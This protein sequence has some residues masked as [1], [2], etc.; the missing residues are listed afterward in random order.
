MHH[1]PVL[2]LDGIPSEID[3]ENVLAKFTKAE[4]SSCESAIDY[5]YHPQGR[6]D[7]EQHAELFSH[8]DRPVEWL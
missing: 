1:Q 8:P 6:C 4:R 2:G 5:D 3:V 7:R